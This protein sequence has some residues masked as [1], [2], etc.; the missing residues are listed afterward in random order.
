MHTAF[1][2][3]E[4]AFSLPAGVLFF[5]FV[6]TPQ[7][8]DVLADTGRQPGSPKA[9]FVFSANPTVEEIFCARVFEEP[10]VPVGG[11]PTAE[12]NAALA[13]ALLRYS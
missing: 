4:R 6:L 11:E 7:V 8:A 13:E 9:P 3:V 2:R 10:V 12:E 5:W 1:R